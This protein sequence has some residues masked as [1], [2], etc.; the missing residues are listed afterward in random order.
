MDELVFH[1]TIFHNQSNETCTTR[2]QNHISVQKIKA[3]EAAEY[4]MYRT[5]SNAVLKGSRLGKGYIG[6]GTLCVLVQ[7]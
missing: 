7:T 1:G 4:K 3:F 6:A 5:K 2:P